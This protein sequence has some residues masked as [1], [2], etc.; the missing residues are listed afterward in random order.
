MS[1]LAGAVNGG[2]AFTAKTYTSECFCLR[3]IIAYIHSVFTRKGDFAKKVTLQLAESDYA[4][5]QKRLFDEPKVTLR[6]VVSDP[7]KN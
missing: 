3:I 2:H 4:K 1:A 5:S 7:A 6:C